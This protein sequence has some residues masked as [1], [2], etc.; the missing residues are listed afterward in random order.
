MFKRRPEYRPGICFL[1]E[2]LVKRYLPYSEIQH[3]DGEMVIPTKPKV[4]IPA[5]ISIVEEKP[6]PVERDVRKG[7]LAFCV[8]HC[9]FSSFAGV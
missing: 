7:F 6:F 9:V 3:Y 2:N 4:S 1:S 5:T 8:F